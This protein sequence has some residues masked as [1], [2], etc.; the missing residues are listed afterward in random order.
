M[1]GPS[2]TTDDEGTRV[3]RV[4]AQTLADVQGLARAA[5]PDELGGILVGW[6]EGDD[7]AVVQA[8]LPVP[9]TDAGR[10]HYERKHS[11]AQQTLDDYLRSGA[12]ISSGYI[13][14]WHSHPAPQPPSSIDR[15]ALSAI[16]R[17]ERRPA[18]L[19]VLA[20]KAAG[21]TDVHGL[22]GHPR[23]PRRAAIKRATIERIES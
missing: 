15:G 22:I 16:V 21:A 8:L 5:L 6:W 3:I 2:V 20:L 9:D 19:V 13:G 18:A 1:Q 12:D 14:E 11:P 23:W 4:S 7:V 17:Q 10:A